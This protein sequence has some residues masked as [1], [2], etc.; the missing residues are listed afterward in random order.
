MICSLC[1]AAA[2]ARAPRNQHCNATGGPGAAC[3]CQHQVDRYRTPAEPTAPETTRAA[4]LLVPVP[5]PDAQ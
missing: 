5:D 4:S 3:D 2:D 1:A